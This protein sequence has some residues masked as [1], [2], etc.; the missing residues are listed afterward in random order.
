[1]AY[2]QNAEEQIIV[3]YFGD[4]KGTFISIGENDGIT[5]SN[6]RRLMEL[7]WKGVCLEPSPKAFAT[8]KENTKPFK[9]VRCYNFALGA[10]NGK[11]EFY[12]SGAHLNDDDHGLLSTMVHSEMNRWNGMKYTKMQVQCF[13][14]KTFLNRI[15]VKEFDMIS[16]DAEGMD[17]EILKQI[18]L[19][20][21]KLLCIEWNSNPELKA[22]YDK[23]TQGFQIIYTSAENLIYARP[24]S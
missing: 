5:L 18:N 6:V 24:R 10:R 15:A 16:L 13:R 7:E 8:L 21:T 14:W 12:D 4:T 17:L 9:N 1:M 19:N 2:S 22:E 11:T 20:F 23:L 3:E